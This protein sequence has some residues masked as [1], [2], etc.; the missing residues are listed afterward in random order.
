VEAETQ[1]PK[2][3][4]Q[5]G[6]LSPFE[7]KGSGM[8][9]FMQGLHERGYVEGQNIII[10]FLTTDYQSAEGREVR[11]AQV[12]AELV[13]LKVDVIVADTNA[14][15]HAAKEASTS[16]PIVFVYSDPVW[17]SL[18]AGL[19]K[20]GGNLTGLS[21]LA[22]Q[23][24][25]KRLEMLKE[26]FPKIYRLA[27]LMNIEASAH[28]REFAEMHGLA[29]ALGVKLQTLG[30]RYSKQD[31][32][33]L[34]Q[35]AISQRASALLTLQGPIVSFHRKR[36]VD[37]A[38]KHRLPAIYPGGGYT[39]AGGLMSYGLNAAHQYRRV[40]YFVDK[41]L[42]GAK[43]SDLPVEQPTKFEL[44]INLQTA[45]TLG[46]TIPPKVLMWADRVIE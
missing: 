38:A 32:D 7:L 13:R 37:L 45:K 21:I 27:V 31:F 6:W 17:D 40:A 33:G 36:I 35:Q 9:A 28:R 43:P 1:Q 26:A 16:I 20:P 22:P 23:L 24:A 30:F 4:P 10:R 34:F 29:E 25:G 41:I 39:D 8:T 19:A 5:V 2:K 18:V 44:V 3:I 42:K 15:T 11:L 46:L 14:A 12:A